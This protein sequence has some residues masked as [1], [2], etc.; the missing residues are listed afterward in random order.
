MS[1]S[2]KRKILLCYPQLELPTFNVILNYSI[3]SIGYFFCKCLFIVFLLFNCLSTQSSAQGRNDEN[4]LAKQSWNDA[5]NIAKDSQL[6]NDQQ[7]EN[8]R[9]LIAPLELT[10]HQDTLGLVYYYIAWR[11]NNVNQHEETIAAT[12]LCISHLKESGYGGY[13]LPYMYQIRASHYK[14]LRKYDLAIADAEAISHLTLSGR[15]IEMLGESIRLIAQIYNERGEYQSAISQLE[16]SLSSDDRKKLTAFTLMNIYYDLSLAYSNFSD[17][18]SMEKAIDAIKSSNEYIPL[19]IYED[20]RL[21]QKILNGQQLGNIAFKQERLSDA[22]KYYEASREL[23]PNQNRNLKQEELYETLTANLIYTYELLSMPE[24]VD[25]TIRTMVILNL[26]D[27][28]K[29]LIEYRTLIYE[30]ISS[31]Y[32]NKRKLDK[33]ELYIDSFYLTLGIDRTIDN[34]AIQSM[35]FKKRVIK[36]LLEEIQ[37]LKLKNF[38]I[39]SDNNNE[40]LLKMNSIDDLV[41]VINQDLLFESSILQWRED[42]Q[43]YYQLGIDLAF[44]ADDHDAFW[45][46]AEKSKSLALLDGISNNILF[47]EQDTIAESVN[48]LNRLRIHESELLSLDINHDT[49]KNQLILNRQRQSELLRKRDTAFKKKIPKVVSLDQMKKLNTKQSI[50]QYVSGKDALYTMLIQ[51]GESSIIKIDENELLKKLSVRAFEILSQPVEDNE[52]LIEWQQLSKQLYDLLL[53]KLGDLE[54]SVV[55]IPEGYLSFLPFDALLNDSDEYLFYDHS[56]YY[57]LSGTL[58]FRSFQKSQ[59]QIKKSIVLVPNYN[60]GNVQRLSGA[61]IE[62]NKICELTSCTLIEAKSLYKMEMYDSIKQADLFHYAGHAVVGDNS[63]EDS[64]LAISDSTRLTEKEI[65]SLSNDLKLVTLSA[66]ET[67]KGELLIGEGISNL[68]RG[69]IYSGARAVVQSLWQVNDGSSTD[70]MELFYKELKKGE[71][72]SDA[73][74]NAKISF[75]NEADDFQRTPYYW[76]SFVLIGSDEAIYFKSGLLIGYGYY[77]IGLSALLIVGLCIFKLFLKKKAR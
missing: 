13:Q 22:A 4:N 12:S 3:R 1:R 63:V 49:I 16:Y 20:E 2:T 24:K 64:Y 75:I 40:A 62:S 15:G 26:N 31:Y 56:I 29:E 32:R 58:Y 76:S 52:T 14:V 28:P 53:G 48:D 51:D 73:L 67:G 39:K 21:N 19:L 57:Q 70:L 42:A 43:Q 44:E 11:H 17:S 77:I 23:I 18:I 66:C 27:V 38:N 34:S 46:Y 25:S 8:L 65:Y 50:L 7:I 45:K 60:D 47:S 37:I 54:E 30:N 9:D 36:G 55:I 74:R 59:S 72:K 10:E 5:I 71:S 61:I 68:S 33:A 69:F 6:S 35:P 41:D